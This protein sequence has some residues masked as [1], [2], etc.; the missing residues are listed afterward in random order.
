M[1][2]TV[3]AR[4]EVTVYLDQVR[5]YLDDL[6]E[7]ERDD[8]LEDLEQHLS[9]V[10]AEG[11][12]PLA[13]RLGSP[14]DYAA[15]L[16]QSAGLP[17]RGAVADSSVARLVERA[18]RS[19][20]GRLATAAAAHRATRAVR[21]FLPE[22][23]PGW[24]VARA[25]VGV[26]AWFATTQYVY[27]HD[28]PVP[29]IAGSR[30]LTLAVVAGAVW[31]SVWLGRRSD[32]TRNLRLVSIAVNVAVVLLAYMAMNELSGRMGVNYVYSEPSPA[33][34]LAHD[35]GSPITNV[36]PYAADGTPLEGVLLYDQT[37][38]PITNVHGPHVHPVGP[39]GTPL[40]NAYPVQE[41]TPSVVPR[42]SVSIPAPRAETTTSTT[43]ATT[44]TTVPGGGTPVVP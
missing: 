18:R 3:H 32:S 6:P 1:T 12:E 22:A 44:T 9:E 39:D 7:A 27:F 4:S 21:D 24:W 16:R 42:P 41:A 10:L 35:D 17:P 25:V 23:R 2:T 28:L 11:D 29:P 19:S 34:Y 8:L 43:A 20:L 14:A 38:R 13:V 33:P 31:A 36:Y 26:A 5:R 40:H 30:L 37:G 15:E